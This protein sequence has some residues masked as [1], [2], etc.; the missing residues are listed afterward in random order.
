MAH[1]VLQMDFPLLTFYRSC[2][3]VVLLALPTPATA[4]RI[5][6]LVDVKG[7]RSNMLEGVGLVVGLAGTGDSANSIAGQAIQSYLRKRGL[8]ITR[9]DIRMRNVAFVA[10]IA[11]LGPYAAA[12]SRLDV[13]VM[14]TGDAQS[15]RGGTLLITPLLDLNGRA[16]AVAQ[17]GVAVGGFDVGVGRLARQRRNTPTSGRIPGGAIVEREVGTKFLRGDL[18][19]LTLKEADFTTA[20]RIVKA[21]NAGLGGQVA[22]T[23]TPG[24]VSLKVPEKYLKNPVEFVSLVEVLT[25]DVDRRARVVLNERTGTVVVGGQVTL[26]PSAVAHGNLDVRIGTRLTASQP[27]PF[28]R[29]GQTAVVPNAGV[30]VG[31]GDTDLKAVPATSTVDELVKALNALGAS[32]QDLVSILQALHAAGALNGDLEVL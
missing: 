4:A 17:G 10:V 23:E 6:D 18:I 21:I 25:V 9:R 29:R 3:L 7:V 19:T 30:K 12:G 8:N 32:P 26:N 15:L 5:K 28:A 2:A 24:S 31:E 1:E 27:A 14:A 20:D 13:K 11:E 22:S 16:F